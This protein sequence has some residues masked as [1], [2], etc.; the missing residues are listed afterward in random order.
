MRPVI[1][2][3]ETVLKGDYTGLLGSYRWGQLCQESIKSK[4]YW[5]GRGPEGNKADDPDVMA[6][7]GGKGVR[8]IR[9]STGT[10]LLSG[11]VSVRRAWIGRGVFVQ[12]LCRGSPAR[13]EG[14]CICRNC[15]CSDLSVLLC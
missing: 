2:V 7:T 6:Y 13:F 12:S 3:E 5:G 9:P 15:D 14:L 1:A 8:L 4:K 10:F 11:R